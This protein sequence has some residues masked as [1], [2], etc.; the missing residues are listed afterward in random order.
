MT[1]G[2]TDLMLR[3]AP[4]A[5]FQ[6]MTSAKSSAS[7]VAR[8]SRTVWL[9]IVIMT[10]IVASGLALLGLSINFTSNISLLALV[11]AYVG[12]TWFYRRVR[13]DETIAGPLEAV[14]Q[15]LV[16]MLLGLLLTY[17]ASATALPYRDAELNA[18]DRWMGFERHQFR[19][20][21]ESVPGLPNL[22]G[23][24][25][26]SI[27]P[28]TAIVPFILVLTRQLP[29]LLRFVFAFGLA[30][31]MT[32]LIAIFV[33]AISASIYIDLAP[34]RE[35]GIP[36]GTYTHIPTLQALRS[37]AMTVIQL[38]DFEGLITFPSFHTT[39]AILFTWALW[40]VPVAR[41]FGL[42]VNG[43]MILSTPLSGSHYVTDLVGGAVV[44][45]IAIGVA[46]R[47]GRYRESELP[48]PSLV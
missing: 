8:L 17:I 3:Y 31:A 6:P 34:L 38:N 20:L 46:N 43:L 41:F 32:S 16:I 22:L 21:I 10:S 11:S 44:A 29:R 45:L 28:Q 19:A 5:A 18:I 2:S 47:I 36:P 15:L 7:E 42:I 13:C 26:L 4:E 9:Q 25:Y 37:G 24:A 14:G 12:L 40:R 33:P 35:A 27:Q 48:R 39:I 1:E 30:L 23:L